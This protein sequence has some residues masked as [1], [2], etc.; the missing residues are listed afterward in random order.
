[1]IRRWNFLPGVPEAGSVVVPMS[2][3]K[4][5]SYHRADYADAGYDGV[6][7]LGMTPCMESFI[8]E[9]N[10]AEGVQ[11]EQQIV[12]TETGNEIMSKFPFETELLE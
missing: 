9:K 4:S 11:L 3:L 5:T 1:M 8:G 6:I 12:I 2:C 7:E 10:A